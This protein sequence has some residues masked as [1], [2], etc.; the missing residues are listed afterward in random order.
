MKRLLLFALL[1]ATPAFA[2]TMNTFALQSGGNQAIEMIPGENPLLTNTFAGTS[3]LSTYPNALVF[4]TSLAPIGS[5]TISFSLSIGGQQFNIPIAS[6]TCTNSGGCTVSADFTMP[7][8][9][10]PTAGTLTVNM[11]GS[12][13]TFDFMFQSAVPE[14]ASLL[15]LGTGLAAIAGWKSRKLAAPRA[16]K[17]R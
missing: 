5:F 3:M 12:G 17:Q 7:T 16:R 4:E 8:F 15:L 2:A 10:H 11:N 14:P 9:Y 1:F 6:D 13:Q